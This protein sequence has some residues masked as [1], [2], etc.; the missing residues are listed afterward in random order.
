[1]EISMQNQDVCSKKTMQSL[2]EK[3]PLPWFMDMFAVV[4]TFQDEKREELN[5][6]NMILFSNLQRISF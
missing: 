2:M 5:V 3:K 4:A 1:M 6:K